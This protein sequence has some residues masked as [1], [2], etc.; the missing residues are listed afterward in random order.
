M[1]KKLSAT[2]SYAS[3]IEPIEPCGP[4]PCSRRP[5]APDVYCVPDP[6]LCGVSR[7]G[8][9][10]WSALRT[11]TAGGRR[12]LCPGKD[13]VSSRGG[14]GCRYHVWPGSATIRECHDPGG[15]RHTRFGL[16]RTCW[17]R[18]GSNL[19]SPQ[20]VAVGVQRGKAQRPGRELLGDAQHP[21]IDAQLG[22]EVLHPRRDLG[23][24]GRSTSAPSTCA[25][26]SR[27]GT[28]RCGP[29]AARRAPAP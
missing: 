22:G 24:N 13:V 3:L 17:S 26:P 1:W 14:R 28:P 15:V 7:P 27:S 2:A 21:V 6:N 12:G 10:H 16:R 23:G 9:P 20:A 5:N 4:A 19:C 29:P 25:G 18:P 8:P 11:G